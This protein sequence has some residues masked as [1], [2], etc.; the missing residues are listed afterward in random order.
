MKTK[1]KEC[2]G[3]FFRMRVNSFLSSH[4]SVETRKSLRL[5]KSVS[6]KGCKYCSYIL[7][8]LKEE[9]G[10]IEDILKNLSDQKIYTIKENVSF[11]FEYGYESEG[12]E[13]TEVK[14]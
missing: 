13:F 12:L 10:E 11:D 3:L 5:L 1:D 8:S 14:Y 9:C 7:D 4:N 6:C 2:K